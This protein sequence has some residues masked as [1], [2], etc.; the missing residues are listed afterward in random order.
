M[1]HQR[2]EF[3]PFYDPYR[4][5]NML[6]MT[7][8]VSLSLSV[9]L[10]YILA[11]FMAISDKM[12]FFEQ[13]LWVLGAIMSTCIMAL[14]AATM[15]FRKSLATIDK[16]EG[17]T[18]LT[19]G[20]VDNWLTDQR[21]VMAGVGFATLNT[22]I[23]H[24]LGVPA[25]IHESVAA[26]TLIYI[27]FFLSGFL[28]GIGLLSI[29]AVI[30]LVLNF[31]PNLQHSLDPEDPDGSGGIGTLGDSLWFFAL[32]IGAV[33]VLVSIFLANVRWTFMYKSYVQLLYLFWL[34]LPYILAVSI[35]LVPGLAVRR[36]VSQYKTYRAEKLKE[37]QSKLYSSYKEFEAGED[38]EII[39]TKRELNE[40]MNKIENQMEKLRKMRK[41]HIDVKDN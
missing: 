18:K 15:A 35:V 36:Q 19:R 3:Y 29:A 5:G 33:G 13:S 8:K 22:A 32:L 1:D 6:S 26:L 40:K 24:L 38:D 21:F 27:G 10:I 12:A 20:I 9:G 17:Q 37:E 34:T 30:K 11:L 16:F 25:V 14:Y 2:T 4:D 39:A 31:A 41:S 28:A 7:A 23:G